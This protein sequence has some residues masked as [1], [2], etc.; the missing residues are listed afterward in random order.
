[1]VAKRAV[2][3]AESM[4][5]QKVGQSAEDWAALKV[6]RTVV[7]KADWTV[8][9]MVLLK[10]EN[11]DIQR[12]AMMAA[13]KVPRRLEKR[14]ACWVETTAP[15]LVVRKADWTVERK[16]VL[17]VDCLVAMREALMVA[18][19]VDQSVDLMAV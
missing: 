17:K 3:M 5:A 15:E 14:G 1:M 6:A 8:D 19:M 2:V 4:A 16:V 9:G 12:A 10:A 11:L 13:S 18:S 7:K